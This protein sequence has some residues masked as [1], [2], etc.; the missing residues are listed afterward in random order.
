MES[1]PLISDGNNSQRERGFSMVEM[2]VT[3]AIVVTIMAIGILQMMPAWRQSQSN[4]ALDQVKSILREARETAISQRRTIVVQFVG[5]DTIELFQMT[6]VAGTPP[7]VTQASAPF[8]TVPIENGVQ[9]LSYSGEPDT[10]DNFGL[11]S[12]P[13][14][15]SFPGAV[16]NP[17]FQSDGTLTDSNG[18]AINGTVFLGV[19]NMPGSAT[20]VT[21]MGST[22]R[23]RAYHSSGN[24]WWQ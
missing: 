20:A 10:P 8:L 3:V 6:V 9:F 24:G 12:V 11:P 14:G 13:D 2:A 16:G 21:V 22:G 7:T 19:P 23:I 1:E 17:Q 15:I 4:A 18:T 5:T